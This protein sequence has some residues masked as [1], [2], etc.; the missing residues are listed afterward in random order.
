M[1]AIIEA[2]RQL[3]WEERLRPAVKL[4]GEWLRVHIYN[5]PKTAGRVVQGLKNRELAVPEGEW[6][7]ASRTIEGKGYVYARYLEPV[8]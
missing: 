1:K 8:A 7:F 5:S 3:V 6:E 4:P 2:P